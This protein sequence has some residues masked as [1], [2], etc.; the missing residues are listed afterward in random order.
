VNVGA[1]EALQGT[2]AP[3]TSK[4][5]H[6]TVAAIARNRVYGQ[7]SRQSL[8]SKFFVYV[9]ERLGELFGPIRGSRNTGIVVVVALVLVL[10]IIIAR[11][12][13]LRHRD[14]RANRNPTS[15]SLSPVA[16]ESWS[17]ARAF[18]AAGNHTEACRALYAAVVDVLVRRGAL[19]RHTSKTGGDYARELRSSASPG[20]RDFA[21]F[22]RD[23]DRVMYGARSATAEDFA[24]LEGQAERALHIAVA[25]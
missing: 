25:A 3:W 11:Q 20:A 21:V 8:I 14:V 2:V 7:P 15:R 17:A 4:Q 10:L 1:T 12:I 23:Y 13:A 5:V 16:S 24:R 9:L 19:R 22:V 6:D 18:A